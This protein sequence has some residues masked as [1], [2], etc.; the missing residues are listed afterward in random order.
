MKYKLVRR[1]NPQDR[2]NTGKLYATPI[3]DGRVAQNEIAVDIVNLSSLARG[4]V[5]NV[6][7]NLIDTVPKYLVMGK[8]VNPGE[9]GSF[10]IPFSSEGVDDPKDFTVD[11]ISGVRI[12]FTP[13]VE[14]RRKL[15]TLRF[16]K[17][18]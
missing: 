2:E 6:I 4:D 13:S 17:G 15:D 8:S 10:R 5:G 16:E 9:L 11:K 3:Y 14:L 18:E 7:N 1:Q 12:V